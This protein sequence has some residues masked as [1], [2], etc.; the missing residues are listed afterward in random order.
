M[1]KK[2]S[3]AR[4]FSYARDFTSFSGWRYAAE[5]G[6]PGLKLGELSTRDGIVFA[7]GRIKV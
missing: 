5:N 7:Q 3:V 4:Y 1:K 6:T 2:K